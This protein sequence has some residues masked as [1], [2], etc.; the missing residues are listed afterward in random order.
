MR[1]RLISMNVGYTIL[2]IYMKYIKEKKD[3]C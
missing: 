1:W 2:E 3:M